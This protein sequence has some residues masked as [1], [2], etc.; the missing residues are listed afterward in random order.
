MR[1]V[2]P[3]L[4]RLVRGCLARD[5][6][7]RWRSAADL[8]MQLRALV[9][10]DAVAAAASAPAG[11]RHGSR[12]AWAIAALAVAAVAAVAVFR[13]AA[14]PEVVRPVRFSIT[15]PPGHTLFQWVEGTTIA[16]APDG[17]RIAFIAADS[18]HVRRI[19]LRPLAEEHASVVPGTDGASSLMWSPDG[20]S[21]AYFTNQTLKRT[22]LDGGVPVTICEIGSGGG[23]AGT[24]GRGGDILFSTI[25]GGAIHRVS[26]AGG[27]PERIVQS[28]GSDGIQWRWPTYLPDGRSFLC[29]ISRLDGSDSIVVIEPGR[30]RYGVIAAESRAE[31]A[32]PGRL[33]YVRDGTLVS[34]PFDWRARRVSG[35]PVAVADRVS[36]FLSNGAATFHTSEDG[37][38]AYAHPEA[39]ARLIWVD[40]SGRETGTLGAPGNYLDLAFSA[41]GARLLASIGAEATGTYDVWSIDLARGDATRI[42]RDRDTE[43]YAI[44]EPGER[45]IVYTA[46]RGR[47]PWLHR[48]D[49][50]T[51]VSSLMRK[52]GF[53]VP[54][55]ITPDGRTLLFRE[56]GE[57]DWGIWAIPLEDSARAT[58]WLN[59]PSDEGVP[60]ISP[61]GRYVAFTSNETGANELYLAPYPGPGEKRR[62]STG[63]AG[64]AVWNPAR[65]E[66]LYLSPRGIVSIPATTAPGLEIGAPALIARPGAGE[67]WLTFD[68]DPAG[69]RLLVVATDRSVPT[70]IQV[71]VHWPEAIA[72]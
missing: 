27:T 9:D 22:D 29:H 64:Q 66:I 68:V 69:E 52:G 47:V 45:R 19:W 31:Y 59:T 57:D 39:S 32:E 72:K 53:A 18:G 2:P 58:P 36:Y 61:D 8:A 1:P 56:R 3:Q 14:P 11:R 55:S 62:I 30:G 70:P 60:R 21:L 67:R 16:V 71:L 54:G 28:S 17:S 65:R 44:W 26:A 10:A 48:H 15:P 42:T 12:L 63:G 24:W 5:P 43:V 46:N 25:H 23:P 6:E 13:P 50:A 41:D 35:E 20:R 33:L 37:T 7:R 38:L 40:R 34:Q 49:L 4:E 51:G